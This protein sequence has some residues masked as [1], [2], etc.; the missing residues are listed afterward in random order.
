[1]LHRILVACLLALAAPA[2]A[3][4]DAADD[5]NRFDRPTIQRQTSRAVGDGLRHDLEEDVLDIPAF[6]RRQAD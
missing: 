4:A 5:C 6:L 1:M 3:L 2:V